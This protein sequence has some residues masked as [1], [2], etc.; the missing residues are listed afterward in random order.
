MS[1]GTAMEIEPDASSPL[2]RQSGPASSIAR[3]AGS[4]DV[5]A[6]GDLKVDVGSP[7]I[8]TA[9]LLGGR[10]AT[11]QLAT[12]TA[13][14]QIAETAGLVFV[15]RYGVLVTFGGEERIEALEAA[16]A[17]HVLEATDVRETE[18]ASLIIVAQ[19]ED[20]INSDGQIIL[21]DPSHERLLLVATVLSRSVILAR[22]EILVSDV[23]DRSAPVVSDLRERGRARLTIRQVMELVGNVLAAR[24]R[25][26]GVVQVS[27]R[28]DL[29]WDH[30]ELDR[31]YNRLEA[32]YEL[33]ERA[34]TLER[35][36]GALGGFS[37]VLLNIVQDKRAFRL[38]A[39]IVALIAVEIV[40][41]LFGMATH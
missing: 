8:A 19:G 32:E 29:L 28:P 37:E 7:L 38:E 9:R 18:T 21:A 20:R 17:H 23:F 35:K 13:F 36:F 11:R 26:M 6:V 4:P 40:L 12:D 33:E 1:P 10:I 41:S 22:D 27:E 31:L 15:F 39:A 30:P 14:L 24:H 34:E 2:P 5:V 3:T 16:I 25:V